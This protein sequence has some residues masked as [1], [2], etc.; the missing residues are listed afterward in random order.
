MLSQSRR[1]VFEFRHPDWYSARTLRILSDANIAL[2]LSDHF[3]APAP[4]KRTADFVYIRGH[5]PSGRYKDHYSEATL[6]QWARRIRGWR[7]RYEVF[8]Y[9]DNDQKSAAPSDAARLKAL[10]RSA[11]S[12][13][14][15]R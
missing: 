9:F 11:R 4:W 12:R 1:Y 3:E 15:A 8:V 10:L 2:C 14:F 5:G 13:A 7:R 6:A